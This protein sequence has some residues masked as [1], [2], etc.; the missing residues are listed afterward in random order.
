[1]DMTILFGRHLIVYNDRAFTERL[2]PVSKIECEMMAERCKMLF[3]LK[4]H[5]ESDSNIFL[6]YFSKSV[7]HR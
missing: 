7:V 6:E 4:I 1:V 2:R 3:L 5:K